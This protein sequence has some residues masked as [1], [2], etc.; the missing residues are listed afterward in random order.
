MNVKESVKREPKKRT[1]SVPSA[2]EQ[3]IKK[4]NGFYWKEEGKGREEKNE[5]GEKK[6]RREE[7]SEKGEK[8]EREDTSEEE[9]EEGRKGGK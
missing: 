1:K 6:E 5:E 4:N 3:K 8:E 7:K 2:E 9:R